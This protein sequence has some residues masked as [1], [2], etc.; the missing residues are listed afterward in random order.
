MR[1]SRPRT[2]VV[3]W[4]VLILALTSVPGGAVPGPAVPGLDKIVHGLLY[5]V[6]G[7]LV[8]RPAAGPRPADREGPGSAAPPSGWLLVATLAIF[9]ASDELHQRWI[10]GRDPSL[11]DWAADVIGAT[12]G[13]LAARVV[14]GRRE[15]RHGGREDEAP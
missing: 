4:A 10:P 12:A 6:L 14:R 8:G 9:A 5:F 11:A 7:L 1:I 15:R 13:L 2:S 3:A